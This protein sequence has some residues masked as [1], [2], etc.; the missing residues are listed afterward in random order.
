MIGAAKESRSFARRCTYGIAHFLARLM[1]VVLF[2]IR[3]AGRHRVPKEGGVLVCANHQSF[4]DPVLVGL[5]CDRRLNYLARQSLFRWAPFRWLIAWFDAI[6][7]ER[8][9]IGIGGL[10]ETLGRLR[11]GE[12]VLIFPEGSRTRDGMVGPIRPG[13]STVARRARVPLVPVG[14]DGAFDAWPRD[15]LLPRSGVI[16][17]QIGEPLQPAQTRKMTEQQLTEE[18]GERMRAC[19]AAARAG[20]HRAIR[21]GRRDCQKRR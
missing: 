2:R 15:K 19:H 10:K 1:A 20:R 14:I 6:P 18:L 16:H 5:A 4:F 13:F 7:I 8:E 9:G 21:A 3:C 11:R 17:I 12:M